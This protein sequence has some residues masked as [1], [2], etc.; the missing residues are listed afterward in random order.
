MYGHSLE[1]IHGNAESLCNREKILVVYVRVT[2]G[3]SVSLVNVMNQ[4]SECKLHTT[5]LL[6]SNPDTSY[7][8]SAIIALSKV[9]DWMYTPSRSKPMEHFRFIMSE[10]ISILIG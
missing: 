5:F 9:S 1:L 10:Y 7:D 6:A 8:K 2:H 4:A 3:V